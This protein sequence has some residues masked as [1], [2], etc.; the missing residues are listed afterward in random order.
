L[1]F[2]R[3]NAYFRHMNDVFLKFSYHPVIKLPQHYAVFDFSN[4]TKQEKNEYK[5]KDTVYGVGKYNEKRPGIYTGPQYEKQNRFIHMGIDIA[6]PVGEAV[7]AF[8]AGQIHSFTYN[9][10]PLDYGYTLIT[11]H[12][13][14][15]KTLYA[16]HGH[17]SKKS[18]QNKIPGQ[19]IQA[20]EVIAYLGNEKENGGWPPHL[21]FQLSWLEPQDCDM[22]GV[23]SEADHAQALKTYPDPQLVLGKLY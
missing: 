2:V 9:D 23:V 3:G 4:S 19:K 8:F 20:G 17:L 6:A 16:L 21:H 18:L 10:A 11:Q 1:Q 14:A 5:Y 22:P 13:L 12:D 7:Y 15:G